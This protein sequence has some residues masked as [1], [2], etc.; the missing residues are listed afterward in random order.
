MEL[1]FWLQE[2]LSTLR[3]GT[4]D[5]PWFD[6]DLPTFDGLDEPVEESGEGVPPGSTGFDVLRREFVR[7]IAGTPE[8]DLR[9]PTT[10]P[11]WLA[12]SKA[13]RALETGGMEA[14]KSTHREMAETLFALVSEVT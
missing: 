5:D 12:A 11:Q 9:N 14:V 8:T 1:T 13:R 6:Q 4:G 7:A 2:L 3:A 10:Q